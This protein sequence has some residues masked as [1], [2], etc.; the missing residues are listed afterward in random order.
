MVR[1]L[2]VLILAVVATSSRAQS[3]AGM[4]F[5]HWYD[6]AS[7]VQFHWKVLNVGDSVHAFYQL[8]VNGQVPV[9]E[10]LLSWEHRESYG[11]RV[12]DVLAEQPVILSS[13]ENKQ[14]GKL[15]FAKPEKPFLLIAKI[16]RTGSSEPNYFFHQIEDSYPVNGYAIQNGLVYDQALKA[17]QATQIVHPDTSTLPITV[18]RYRTEFPIASPPFVEKENRVDPLLIAD[19]TFRIANHASFVP[20]VPGLY[21]FQSDTNAAAGFCYFVGEPD[22][23]KFVKLSDVAAPLIFICTKEEYDQIELAGNDKAKFDKVILDITKDG[24]RARNFMRSYFRRVELANRYFTSYKAGWK[25]DRGMIYTIFGPPDEV[26]K[27]GNN[28]LW[29]Y[30]S[31]QVKFNFVR[32]ASIFDPNNYVLLRDKR[33]GE[34]WFSTID[35]WRKSRF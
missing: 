10:Y 34:K 29:N 17:G 6:P 12:S 4:N 3:I 25:T 20:K 2:L 1:F 5:R 27:T 15:S 35:L 33:F 21:L 24:E 30:K 32:S 22:Y 7:E 28:E 11:Q 16:L 18:Y 8:S 9:T 31:H 19:S 26:T 13:S 23:P 14:E